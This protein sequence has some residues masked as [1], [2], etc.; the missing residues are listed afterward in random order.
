MHAFL[1][2]FLLGLAI[3]LTLYI[4]RKRIEAKLR[5]EIAKLQDAVG[6]LL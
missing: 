1:Y 5:S 6:R 4:S 3:A 2:G